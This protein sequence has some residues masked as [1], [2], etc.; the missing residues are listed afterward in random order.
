M[1]VKLLSLLCVFFCISVMKLTTAPSRRQSAHSHAVWCIEQH[2]M[3]S[4]KHR[5]Q[6]MLL[7][8]LMYSW[9]VL[10]ARMIVMSGFVFGISLRVMS[11][12]SELTE[13]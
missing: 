9:M 6:Q 11:S 5:Q 10:S 1:C 2:S 3:S 13:C 4:H 12:V 7:H 8:P